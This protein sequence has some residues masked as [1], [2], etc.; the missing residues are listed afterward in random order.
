ML[1][2]QFASGFKAGGFAIATCDYSYEPEVLD[3]Y[4]LGFKATWFDRLLR[5]NGAVFHYDYSNLQVEEVNIPNAFVNNA[6]A[7]GFGADFDLLLIPGSHWVL[8][9]NITYLD[10][11]YTGF[12]NND[13]AATLESGLG[14]SEAEDLSGNRLNRSPE[15]AMGWSIQYTRP[16]QNWG[17]LS[18]R[19]E[20]SFKT[21][22]YLR[23]FST[24]TDRQDAH[25]I[26]NFFLNY[27]TPIQ[28]LT[29]W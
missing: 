6:Q 16:L 25:A 1:Y 23:E 12:F 18:L 26:F 7:K 13:N 19:A 5:S 4:E 10:A 27:S 15:W 2:A 9:A 17:E 24:P 3:A 29:G 22:Y 28:G 14:L 11:T 8:A 20:G 21:E